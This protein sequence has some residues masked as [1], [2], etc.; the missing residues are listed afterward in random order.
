[1]EAKPMS[2]KTVKEFF[3]KV[4]V[5]K[6]IQEKIKEVDKIRN[7][8]LNDAL[9]KIVEIAKSE[10]FYFS[11]EDLIEARKEAY[12][13]K[14]ESDETKPGGQKEKK[15]EWEDCWL[16]AGCGWNIL[17]TG[18]PECGGGQ[19]YIPPAPPIPED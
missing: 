2:I 8:A 3:E 5:D 19:S 7:N 6:S 13:N 14:A 9:N 4:V 16:N 11:S 17:W 18:P 12:V 1:M 15:D 10:G